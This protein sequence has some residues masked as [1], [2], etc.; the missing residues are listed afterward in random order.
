M[1]FVI[2][3]LMRNIEEKF[4]VTGFTPGADPDE[5]ITESEIAYIPALAVAGI[6]TFPL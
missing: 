6:V 4:S 1:G 5:A 3:R 2:S